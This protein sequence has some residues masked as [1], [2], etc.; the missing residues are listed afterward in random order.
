[1][2]DCEQF[3]DALE[4]HQLSIYAGVPD[5]LLKPICACI[6]GRSRPQQHII[7]ANEGAAVG[8][9]TGSYL[10]TGKPGM[11]YMQNSGLGNAVNPLLSLTDPKVYSIPMLM[12]I[13]WRGEPGVK[14]EPQHIKQGEVT[15]ELLDT[16]GIPYEI[17][18]EETSAACETLIKMLE[19]SISQSQP[20]ALVVRKNT[21]A[22]Y[23]IDPDNTET[24]PLTREQS[25]SLSPDELNDDDIIVSTTGM[26]SREIFEIRESSGKSHEQDFLTVGSMGHCSQIAMGIALNKPKQRVICIDGDGS[27]IMHMGSLAITG[28]N[29]S[30]CGILHIVINNGRHD[31][32]GGQPT[33]GQSINIPAIAQACGYSQAVSVSEPEALRE[34][35]RDI[36]SLDSPIMI[37]VNV[38]GGARSELGRPTTTPL[39]NKKAFMDHLNQSS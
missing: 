3:F 13:G 15:L 4:Q 30:E 32:V 22:P 27:L 29:S 2:I 11:V 20:V 24:L 9:A 7:A 12:L 1:M 21:F 38:R 14:D 36:N 34:A 37:E 28:Q 5:S 26:T 39:E 17:L 8:L 35:L 19:K 6:T 23:Q 31:S 25:L 10:A 18:P 33:A 16:L